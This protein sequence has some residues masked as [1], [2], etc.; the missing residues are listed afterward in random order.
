MMNKA[1]RYRSHL[2]S[3]LNQMKWELITYQCQVDAQVNRWNR[4]VRD[5]QSMRTLRLAS[6]VGLMMCTARREIAE[7]AVAKQER[8]NNAVAKKLELAEERV[9]RLAKVGR[10]LEGV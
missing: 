4:I 6:R 1:T 9:K 10:F 3:K 7:K 8:K 5:A 2:V